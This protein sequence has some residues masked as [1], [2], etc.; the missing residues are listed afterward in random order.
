MTI[1]DDELKKKLT[2]QQYHVMREKGTEPP[3]RGKFLYNKKN[4][5]YSCAACGQNLFSSKAKFD[6]SCGWPS[7]DLPISGDSIKT[8]EDRSH[9]MARVEVKCSK[10]GSHLGH[11]FDDGPTKTGL[12]YCINSCGL[13]FK[14]D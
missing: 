3:F 1:N 12:R 14:D 6:S 5:I 2:P 4:G 8:E 10:C 11:V 9:G 7:F 13:E